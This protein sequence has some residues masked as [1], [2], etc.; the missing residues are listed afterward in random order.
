MNKGD[1][2]KMFPSI[3]KK[4]TKEE[5]ESIRSRIKQDNFKFNDLDSPRTHIR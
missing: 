3:P 5:L 1:L 2:D 4:Y